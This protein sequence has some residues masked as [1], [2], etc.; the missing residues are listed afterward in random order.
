MTGVQTCALPI[1]FGLEPACAELAAELDRGGSDAES[2]HLA[3]CYD[4]GLAR[5][6]AALADCGERARAEK[7]RAEAVARL[8]DGLSFDGREFI[9]VP[10]E[11]VPSDPAR[12]AR[13]AL[14]PYDDGRWLARLR[15]SAAE[16]SLQEERERLFLS[17][18]E[19]ENRVLARLSA[20]VAGA[21]P[22]LAAA[23]AA[24]ARWD[25]ARAGAVLAA[26]WGM[27]RPD[28]GSDSMVLE[29]ARFVPCQLECGRLGLSYSP[30]SA[31]F[32]ADAVVLF[33]SNMGGKTVVL[34][35]VLFFQ[36]LAQCGLF[37]PAGTFRT[38]VYRRIEYVGEL[39]GERLAGLSGFG[40][41][42][43]RLERAWR[44]SGDA[45]IAFDE[46]ARTTGSHEAEAL[47]SAIVEA[48]AAGRGGAAGER[49]ARAFFATHFRGVARVPGAEYRRMLG[50][51]RDAAIQAL[52]GDAPLA[53]RLAGI[54]RH[55]RYRVVED[56]GGSAGESD[57]LAVAAML[58]LDG[59]LVERATAFYEGTAGEVKD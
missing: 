50:L 30:L 52:D 54:N 43:W 55:M 11:S 31:R 38:R 9:L 24:I 20:M 27:T 58:G 37:V 23:A 17:E 1:S 41:E 42:V 45:L 59:A 14:E 56:L 39:A 8:E 28:L 3:D 40:F 47:L 46:L 22:E 5:V 18:R 34:K 49:P 32:G 36:L 33:G 53:A 13:Y 26:E 19:A 25:L 57:A 2:F 48:Y 51:D 15:P 21:I 44:E 7:A 6:R 29:E 4:E 12:A 35:T 10:R 16:L